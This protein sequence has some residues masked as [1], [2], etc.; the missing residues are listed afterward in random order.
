MPLDVTIIMNLEKVTQNSNA[1]EQLLYFTST[2]LT[3]TDERLIFMSDRCGNTNIY[4]LCLRT[5]KEQKLSDNTDGFLK[6]YVYFDGSPYEGLGK[7]SPS[8]HAE[9]STLY[10][11]QGKE[12]RKV[13]SNGKKT[14]L[15]NLPD[16]QMTAFTHV[17]S[18]NR[19]LCVPTTDERALGGKEKLSDGRPNY[20]IDE[21]VQSESLS[22]YLRVYDTT[23]GEEIL[24]EQVKKAWITH[25]QFNPT[26]SDQ[27]LYNH[28]WPSQCGIRRMWLFDGKNH[29]R[30]RSEGKGISC[31]DYT[32]H[33]MW[34]R[35]GS[36]IVY[37]GAYKDKRPYIGRVHSDGTNHQEILIENG[38]NRYGHFTVGESGVLVSDGY[39]ESNGDKKSSGG[40]WICRIDVDW[41][42]GESNWVPLCRNASSWD[43]QDSHPHPIIDHRNNYVYFTSD[44]EGKRAVYRTPLYPA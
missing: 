13:T 18:D 40:D 17:S 29:I 27:I 35:D 8:F 5:K 6:S 30:L 43:S 12:I 22:S 44:M 4:S 3:S 33:E 31:D 20:N 1:N 2:S 16:D 11:I 38:S 36:A 42:N 34:E 37:H 39:Y 25:V 15:A 19:R 24:T 9:S 23:T 28:E 41:K 10:Y 7:A 32:C 14:I 26:N 21:R